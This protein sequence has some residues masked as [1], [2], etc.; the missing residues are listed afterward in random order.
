[1]LIIFSFFTYLIKEVT[2]Y[3]FTLIITTS[4][5]FGLDETL[6]L[7]LNLKRKNCKIYDTMRLVCEQINKIMINLLNWEMKIKN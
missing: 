1:M 5:Y 4:E 7:E 6:L 2:F 3:D